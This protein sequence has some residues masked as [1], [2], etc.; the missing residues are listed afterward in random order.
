MQ[1]GLFLK[2]LIIMKIFLP[3]LLSLFSFTTMAQQV[4][5][6]Y[7]TIPNSKTDP[8][9]KEKSEATKEGILR[10]SEVVEPTLTVFLPAKGKGNGTAVVICPG[11]GYWIVAAG[12]EGYD[13]AKE[14]AAVGIAAF[15]LKYRLPDSRIQINPEIA[16]LQDAQRAIQLVRER[17]K[18][19]SINPQQVGIMGFSAGGHLASTVGTKFNQPVIENK[20]GVNLRP[21]FMILIYPVISSDALIAHKGSFEKL[22]GKD[23][24]S[25]KLLLYSNEKQVTAQT[26]PTFLVHASDDNGVS[27]LNSTAFYEALLKNKVPAEL[28]LYQNGGHGFGMKN[29]TTKD[30]WMDRLMNWMRANKWL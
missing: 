12:H 26:P 5:P 24:S 29:P 30:A 27:G 6:L 3:F 17:A 25:E 7:T 1:I 22:L 19:W 4:L 13:V 9:V 15:V 21:D 20:A 16:P 2:T 18:E 10:I 14:F 11:G 8:S 23:A 28:H